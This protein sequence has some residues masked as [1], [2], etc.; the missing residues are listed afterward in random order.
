[1]DAAGN[2]KDFLDHIKAMEEDPL[3]DLLCQLT[4]E[5]S[6]WYLEEMHLINT[7]G[8]NNYSDERMEVRAFYQDVKFKRNE[9][10][11][12]LYELWRREQ[13]ARRERVGSQLP[14]DQ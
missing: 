2:T 4:I 10:G 3:R 7:E 1:M 6:R 13:V 14:Q 5:E 11:L 12:Q 8:G 9:V